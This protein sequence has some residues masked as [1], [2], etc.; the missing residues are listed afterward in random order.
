MDPLDLMEGEEEDGG[1]YGEEEEGGRDVTL[2]SLI[3]L[4]S[5]NNHLNSTWRVSGRNQFKA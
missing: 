3:S 4:F 5:N 1:I 2:D